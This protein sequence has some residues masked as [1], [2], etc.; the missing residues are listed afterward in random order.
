[1]KSTPLLSVLATLCL[2]G[3]IVIGTAATEGVSTAQRVMTDFVMPV[4]LG[5]L[6]AFGIAVDSFLR[7][8]IASVVVFGI[9]F[10][11]IGGLFS[12]VVAERM[13]RATETPIPRESPLADDA[14][15]YH[16]VVVLGGG[17]FRNAAGHAQMGIS[18][19][20]LA[21]AAKMWH[22]GKVDRIICTGTAKPQSPPMVDFGPRFEASGGFDESDPAE[23]GREILVALGVPPSRIIRSGGQNTTAE[24]RHLA[25][26]LA[27]PPEAFLAPVSS[28]GASP[29][30]QPG[31]SPQA[32]RLG[33]ITSAFHLPRAVR[34]A[35]AR[36]LDFTPIAADSLV[37]SRNDRGIGIWVPTA[38]AGDH[39]AK[40]TKEW[41]A[42]ILG[43]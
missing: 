10:L 14:A 18:G 22:A 33:L 9:V 43:R 24:M 2:A 16:A 31:A 21:L 28:D 30:V 20:R 34:L 36:Q 38:S 25:A 12:P 23:V 15:S 41:L 39:V 27:E 26:W 13:I 1:M 17:A 35:E 11:L 40:I 42:R 4:G 19:E 3:V 6:A 32:I 37:A 7:R 8:R 5:W 29:D